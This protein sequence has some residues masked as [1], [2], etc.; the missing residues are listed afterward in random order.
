[1]T[2]GRGPPSSRSPA[3]VT[4]AIS[5]TRQCPAYCRAELRT[6]PG[7][8]PLLEELLHAL[9]GIGSHRVER[10]HRFGEVVGLALVDVDL[11]VEG[12]LADLQ[13]QRACIGDGGGQL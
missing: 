1:M 9:L 5:P 3:P 7:R 10:H 4:T 11:P 8:A 12:V 6:G 13:R 2:A